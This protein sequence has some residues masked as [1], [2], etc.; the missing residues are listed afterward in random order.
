[1][2]RISTRSISI[3]AWKRSAIA[4]RDPKWSPARSSCARRAPATFGRNKGI[5]VVLR[6]LGRTQVC[7]GDVVQVH[8]ALANYST[9]SVT[10]TSN[11]WFSSDDVWDTGDSISP[12]SKVYTVPAATA[13]NKYWGYEFPDLKLF[14]ARTFYVIVRVTATTASGVTVHDSIPMLGTVSAGS[15]CMSPQAN[16]A[17]PTGV[18]VPHP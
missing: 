12:T 13:H 3:Q 1:M 18:L 17:P 16:T 7:P 10:V 5:P 15:Q 8:Y 6:R 14:T 4:T 9:S 11:V 2:R